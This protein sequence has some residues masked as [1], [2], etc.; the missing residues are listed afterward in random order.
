MKSSDMKLNSKIISPCNKIWIVIK[1]YG[2]GLWLIR[3]G[4]KN[5]KVCFLAQGQLRMFKLKA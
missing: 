4:H 5:G 3:R 1:K 2:P